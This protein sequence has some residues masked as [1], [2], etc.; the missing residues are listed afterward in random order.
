MG[1]V[2][3]FCLWFCL[4]VLRYCFQ[5]KLPLCL[6][7]QQGRFASTQS[8]METQITPGGPFEMQQGTNSQHRAQS[9]LPYLLK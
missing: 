7:I 1:L 3:W 2:F 6:K 9:G 5:F 8:Q 4:F